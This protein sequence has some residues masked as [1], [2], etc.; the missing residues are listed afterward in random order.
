MKQKNA[1]AVAG[2]VALLLALAL[3][4]TFP[5]LSSRILTTFD[6]RGSLVKFAAMAV[7]WTNGDL[8]GRWTPDILWGY[9]YPIF[10]FYSPLFYYFAAGLSFVLPGVLAF[11]VSLMAVFA[12]AGLSMFLFAREFWGKGGGLLSAA[13]YLAAPYHLLN[14][15]VRGSSAELTG[16]AVIPLVF[17]AIFRL[18]SAFDGGIF[19]LG[20]LASALLMLSHNITALFYFPM[21][22][23]Y[24]GF[25]FLTGPVRR[26]ATIVMPFLLLAGGLFLS[27]YFWLPALLERK[28]VQLWRIDGGMYDFH[29]HFLYIK[30]LLYAPW[31][32][33]DSAP[34]PNDGMSLMVGP[35]HLLLALLAGIVIF[36]RVDLQ[37]VRRQIVFFG[38][39][40]IAAAFMSL[41]A[42]CFLWEKL[43]L[44]HCAQFPWR[45]LMVMALAVSLV[46]GGSACILR[47]KARRWALAAVLAVLVLVTLPMT[48]PFGY[49]ETGF[50]NIKDFLVHSA[51][52]DNMEYLPVGARP[53]PF[54]EPVQKMYAIKGR[55]EATV[56]K[57][58]K[59][60]EAQYVIRVLEPSVM[61]YHSYYFPG[62]KVSADGKDVALVDDNPL[63]LIVFMLPPGEHQVRIYFTDTPVRRVAAGISMAA[64]VCF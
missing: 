12:A 6:Y 42:S 34:G 11:N 48:R 56:L 19:L 35:L 52:W 21:L 61:V 32:F 30:Q 33:G 49:E 16:Y 44:L 20:A 31:G 22:I 62:W 60:T 29:R 64:W 1:A 10:N 38:A 4:L 39:A 24:A 41:G 47:G 23:L 17:W 57:A 9:G 63:G 46:G 3:L 13:L 53:M 14:L 54:K 58:L 50:K 59:G 37:G 36:R 15:Y 26:P 28:Y 25:L 27:A 55:I 8:A 51:P 40:F 18:S 43:P 2:V 7:S 45:F 5:L